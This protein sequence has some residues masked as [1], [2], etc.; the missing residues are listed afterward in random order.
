MTEAIREFIVL[1]EAEADYVT[2]TGI[3]EK[4]IRENAPEWLREILELSPS[5]LFSWAGLISGTSFSCWANYRNIASQF[6][7]SG[8]RS[9]RFLGHDTALKFDYAIGWKVLQLIDFIKHND[10]RNIPAVLFIRDADHQ[11]RERLNSLNA[12]RDGFSVNGPQVI[13]GLAIP[14]REA[15]VLNGFDPQTEDEIKLFKKVRGELDLDP[16]TEAHR[17]RGKINQPGIESRDI[18]RVLME[19]VDNNPS[20]EEQC[21][22]T[23]SL[24]V[25]IARG[26]ETGLTDYIENVRAFLIP[27]LIRN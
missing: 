18:K 14:K 2:A 13:I 12:L 8:F 21:W 22:Q 1:V 19:L 10:Q 15:W 17:L 9:P 27:L 5:S 6:E 20:R 7:Q 26:R 4:V 3:A 23:T 24:A 16:C 25:L 11:A